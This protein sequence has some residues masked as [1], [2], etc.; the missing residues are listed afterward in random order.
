VLDSDGHDT[1]LTEIPDIAR[2][3]VWPG[4]MSRSWRNAFI[5]RWAG[6]EWELRAR[7]PEAEAALDRARGIG[8]ADNAVLYIGQDAGL[9]HDIPPAGEIVE[10]IMAEAEALLKDRL[11]RLVR[12]G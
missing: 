2:A 11:P 1:V 12:T 3:S 9:I 10:R 7:Q 5:E 6:R 4:A 8:D